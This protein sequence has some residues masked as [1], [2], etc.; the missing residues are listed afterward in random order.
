MCTTKVSYREAGHFKNCLNGWLETMLQ[1]SHSFRTVSKLIQHNRQVCTDIIQTVLSACVLSFMR[2]R[3]KIH[4]LHILTLFSR[5]QFDSIKS[6][7]MKNYEIIF[8]V[9]SHSKAYLI[10]EKYKKMGY[11]FWDLYF[12]FGIVFVR[13]LMKMLRLKFITTNWP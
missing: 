12:Y 6:I 2:L 3:W 8:W 1:L 10:L 5:H 13:L 4:R 7:E 9:C 11:Y